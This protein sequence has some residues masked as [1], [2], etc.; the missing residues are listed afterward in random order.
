MT[1][2]EQKEY[3]VRLEKVN[4]EK[5]SKRDFTINEI[6]TI[7]KYLALKYSRTN[8]TVKLVQEYDEY[9]KELTH[10]EKTLIGIVRK[11]AL[12][13]YRSQT[14]SNLLNKY[15]II[16]DVLKN[17][18]P[19]KIILNLAE[20]NLRKHA[21][22]NFM[23]KYGGI[24]SFEMRKIYKKTYNFSNT[25]AAK[26]FVEK[27]KNLGINFENLFGYLSQTGKIKSTEEDMKWLHYLIRIIQTPAPKKEDEATKKST[28]KPTEIPSKKEESTISEADK[29]LINIF[30]GDK[31]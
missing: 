14:G 12:Q 9:G 29:E 3:I 24:I 4:A 18:T 23:N 25:K 21:I 20:E 22:R 5:G 27:H 16:L 19:G 1:P 17:I 15:T 30:Y 10:F 13:T 26:K 7:E 28:A 11:R 6:K 2:K 8:N 31:Q